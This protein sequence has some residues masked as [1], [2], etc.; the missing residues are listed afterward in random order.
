M[1]NKVKHSKKRVLWILFAF[2]LA[3]TGC[4]HVKSAKKLIR[5]AKRLHGPCEVVSSEESEDKTVVVLRDKLQGFEY[6]ISSKMQG[7]VIDGSSFGSLPYTLDTFKESL[8]TFA[9]DSAKDELDM[10]GE[11][12]HAEYEPKYGE[13]IV[14]YT[15]SADMPDDTAAKIVQ[16][17]SQALQT[18]NVNNRMDGMEVHVEHDKEWLKRMLDQGISVKGLDHEYMLSSGGSAVARHI[19]SAVLPDCRFRDLEEEEQD[20]YIDMA[21]MK[22]EKARFLR[23]E[24]KTLADTGISVDRVSVQYDKPYPKKSSDPVTFYYFTVDGREFFICDFIDL[25]TETWF[26]DYKEK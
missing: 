5:S 16:E 12:Y 1:K 4:G 18:Y 26:T 11:K 15:M 23:K 17:A 21:H 25:E 8:Q 9:V 10:I 2:C 22:N 6:R 14:K 19:G 20:Y 7:I 13:V 3:L 24:K